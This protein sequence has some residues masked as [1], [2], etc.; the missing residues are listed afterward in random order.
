LIQEDAW[1]DPAS[2]SDATKARAMALD[3]LLPLLASPDSGKPL[4]MAAGGVALE[5]DGE[6]FPILDS[7]PLLFPA[8]VQP[9][10][11]ADGLDIPAGG[12]DALLKYLHI[13]SLKQFHEPTNSEHTDLN[14]LKHV[15]RARLLM[16]NAAGTAL[17]VGC[18][19]PEISRTLFPAG[20]DYIGLEPTYADRSQF[21]LIGIAEALPFRDGCLDN[22]AMLTSLDHILDY[23]AAIDEAWRVL[24][25]GGMLYLATLIWTASAELTR[26]H[27]HFH[28]F[29]DFEIL[30]ALRRL[31]IH[32]LHRY[33]WK[34]NT[35]RFSWY[36][37]ARK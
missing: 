19:V 30:G 17:D 37:C 21:R 5:A 20:V 36:L 2:I 7:L 9:Y 35:H 8:R 15:H 24:R 33:E 14:Y 1:L 25:P 29:R 34:G 32:E 12:S 6:A 4:R 16:R 11:T 28:H 23:H 27:I 31:S 13:A 18:D 26:D 10:V 22:V 3:E